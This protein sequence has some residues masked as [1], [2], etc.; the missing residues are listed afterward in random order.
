MN[1]KD[2][3]LI[4]LNSWLDSAEKLKHDEL[5]PSNTYIKFKTWAVVWHDRILLNKPSSHGFQPR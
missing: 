2:I 5:M 3:A 1:T 4:H